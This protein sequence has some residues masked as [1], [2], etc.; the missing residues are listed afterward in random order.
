MSNDV[1]VLQDVEPRKKT[2]P[3]YDISLQHTHFRKDHKFDDS[4]PVK[5]FGDKIIKEEG[6]HWD[7]IG[8]NPSICRKLY[9]LGQV[10]KQRLGIDLRLGSLDNH[11]WFTQ[12]NRLCPDDPE[13]GIIR[14]CFN[15]GS[16]LINNEFIPYTELK[17]K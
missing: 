8:K 13:N 9:G 12:V 5:Y 17:K 14:I 2:V 4:N 7:E 16:L 1:N 3:P 11:V 10:V 15:C 6:A